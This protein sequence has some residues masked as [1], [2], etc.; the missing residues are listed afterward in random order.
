MAC[1][2]PR[3]ARQCPHYGDWYQSGNKGLENGVQ[4]LKAELAAMRVEMVGLKSSLGGDSVQIGGATFHSAYELETWLDA[5]T[6]G[7]FPVGC[8]YNIVSLFELML[9]TSTDFG[10]ARCFE[11]SGFQH[12]ERE[13]GGQFVHHYGSGSLFADFQG[14]TTLLSCSVLQ[15]LG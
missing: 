15:G 1:N 12:L 14:R 13:P 4:L 10:T 5:N 3:N 7:N 11:Q 9:D 6:A 2:C 8:W